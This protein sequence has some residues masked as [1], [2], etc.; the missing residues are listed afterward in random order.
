MLSM[1]WFPVLLLAYV[2]IGIQAGISPEV[3]VHGFGPNLGLLIIVFVA[4]GAPREQA[5]LACVLIGAMQ[6][7]ATQQAPG[8]YALSYGLIAWLI[9]GL[10][11]VVYRQHPLTHATFVLLGGIISGLIIWIHGRVLPP[12]ASL[13]M[14]PGTAIYTAILA[15]PALWALQRS[16]RAFGM[17]SQRRG[18]G[19]F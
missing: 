10:Q 14:V 9:V 2:A 6:D 1:R 8:L 3:R 11:N 15:V 4:L 18:R 12:P 17:S 16:R 5:L 13:S 19:A 7:L